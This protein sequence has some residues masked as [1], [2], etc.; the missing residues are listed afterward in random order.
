MAENLRLI[1]KPISS[2]DSNLP[3]GETYVIPASDSSAFSTS[4]D[5]DS[6][7]LD[8]TYGGYYN[9]YTATA[10]WGTTN[11]GDGN[12]PKDIC[13]KGWRLPTGGSSGEFQTLYNNY[14]SLALMQGEP[15][16]TLSGRVYLLSVSHQGSYG[17][18]WSSTIANAP[19][20]LL[21]DSS[22]GVSPNSSSNT[23]SGYSVRCVAY[24]ESMQNFDE[25]T[26]SAGQSKRLVDERD[27]NVYTVK[28]LADGHVWMIEN[29]RLGK[30]TAMTL[31]P[32]DSDVARNY[33][34]PAKI[35]TLSSSDFRSYNV[36]NVYIDNTYGGY[37]TFHAATAGT[38]S[39]ISV[40]LGEAPSSIC[41]KG[42][43]LPTG[44]SSG[45]FDTL[46][47]TYLN[48]DYNRMR[49]EAGFD[50]S[51]KISQGSIVG[52]GSRGDYWSSNYAIANAA[53]K[54]AL[55]DSSVNAT[56]YQPRFE[57]YAIR[58]VAEYRTI[59]DITYMN[60]ISPKIVEKTAVGTSATLKDR[61]NS[62]NY[63]VKKLTDGHVWMTQNLSL[64]KT[65]AM[66][67]TPA[68]SDVSSNWELPAKIDTLFST[69]F[70]SK[71][72][73]NYYIDST[74]GGYYNYY[75]L[76]AGT[77]DASLINDNSATASICPIGWKLP[78]G[79]SADSEYGVLI[80]QYNSVTDLKNA[81]GLA[82]TGYIG[83]GTIQ[84][85]GQFG[86]YPAIN[87]DTANNERLLRV[88]DGG[89]VT[90]GIHLNKSYGVPVRCIARY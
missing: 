18:Y 45:E 44:A 56:T 37:Y 73:K 23:R 26:L 5:T 9:F 66:T 87:A 3:S 20:N 60:Q 41:P 86:Y 65:S 15:G 69:D 61:R 40:T 24:N 32:D 39:G 36:S 6:A 10:G 76:T 17:Y 59:S 35:E 11:E 33:Q 21:L 2:T 84:Y 79:G 80:A 75:T 67:L 74:Y 55:T 27:G 14:N 72:V 64:G 71:D 68:D 16:F 7:Y 70:T 88:N 77:G 31:T 19:R 22:S 89:M 53:Y 50:L 47:N 25:S 63:A 34:H 48:G 83:S 43:R 12:A 4:Y 1:N 30:D 78:T 82:Y 38:N 62:T 52:Q 54:L 29:L 90:V 51:G 81:A 13:P 85:Q 49:N 58:C 42:W 8:S 28:K 46:Y 57:G